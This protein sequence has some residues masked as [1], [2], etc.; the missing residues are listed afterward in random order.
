MPNFFIRVAGAPF[1][2]RRVTISTTSA[3]VSSVFGFFED[4][5]AGAFAYTRG[6]FFMRA[7]Y[8]RRLSARMSGEESADEPMRPL[9]VFDNPDKLGT[10]PSGDDPA[11]PTWPFRLLASGP[12]GVGKRN[13]LLNI[14]FR[15]RPPPSAIHVVHYDPETSEY[16]VLE[17]LGVPMFYYAPE[18]FPTADN[19]SN[20]EPPP[21]GDTEDPPAALD[22]ETADGGEEAEPPNL[23]SDPLIIIDEVTDAGLSP[24][25]ANRFERLLNYVSS[26]K[27]TTVLCS[28]QSVVNLP[29]KARRGFNQFVLWP[30]PDTAATTM[31]ATRAGVP[32]AELQELFGLCRGRHESIWV[33]TTQPPGSP[34]RFRLNMVCP[35]TCDGAAAE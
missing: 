11:L 8:T 28:I 35:I 24:G 14:A 21:L 30:Q 3:S 13:L 29:A 19:L 16:E 6:A 2:F 27:N 25:S 15:L 1:S 4:M 18:D 17:D 34:W 10:R 33:D 9:L 22:A 23:G 12:P 26:H 7:K 31:A 20:P 32:P 5:G